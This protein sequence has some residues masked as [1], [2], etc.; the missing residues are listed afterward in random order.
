M[1]LPLALRGRRRSTAR[2]MRDWL[3]AHKPAGSVGVHLLLAALMWSLV[4]AALL[5]L[6]V[7]WVLGGQSRLALPLV[8]CP[9]TTKGEPRRSG[10]RA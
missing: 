4:G 6:G 9:G 1:S 7:L 8:S 2:V 10:S 3:D 5:V